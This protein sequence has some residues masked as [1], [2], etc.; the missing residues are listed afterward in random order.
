ATQACLCWTQTTTS[1]ATR[2]AAL[3]PRNPAAPTPTSPETARPPPQ[4]APVSLHDALPISMTMGFKR[5]ATGLP[6]DVHVGDTMAF[7][8][9]EIGRAH[10]LT[11]VT[12]RSR[13]PSSA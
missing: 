3:P 13:M 1:R 11:P 8:I 9:R 10:V 7:E 6:R 5:P 2:K 4:R 12:V